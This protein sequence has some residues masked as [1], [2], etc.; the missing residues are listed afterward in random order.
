MQWSYYVTL[1][2]FSDNNNH[3]CIVPY[4]KASEAWCW[5][6]FN[7]EKISHWCVE[8]VEMVDTDE[9]KTL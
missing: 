2:L 8:S 1:L 7:A 4:V 9:H 5:W 6:Q 3:I